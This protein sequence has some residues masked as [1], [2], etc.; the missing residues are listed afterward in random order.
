MAQDENQITPQPQ[1]IALINEFVAMLLQ[2]TGENDVVHVLKTQDDGTLRTWAVQVG[3]DPNGAERI[4]AVEEDGTLRNAVV[5]VGPGGELENLEKNRQGELKVTGR[6][7]GLDE[8][9]FQLKRIADTLEC[10]R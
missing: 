1:E 4:V 3:R 6:T 10:W 2:G 5:A 9:A 7:F 8:I